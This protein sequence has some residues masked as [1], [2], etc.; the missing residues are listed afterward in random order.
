MFRSAI[1]CNLSFILCISRPEIVV[2]NQFFPVHSFPHTFKYKGKKGIV[3]SRLD[4]K[5]QPSHLDLKQQLSRLD[6]KHKTS[7][8]DLKQLQ[9]S[10][11]L[12][13]KKVVGLKIEFS[14]WTLNQSLV[15][16]T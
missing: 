14:R 7:R 2:I 16:R 5:Q 13:T 15:V 12:K 10:L 1:L 11:D 3:L 8:L 9:Q 4:S 6:L